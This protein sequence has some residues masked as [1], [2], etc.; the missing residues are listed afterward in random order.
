MAMGY[1]FNDRPYQ[2]YIK[3]QD[4]IILNN[5]ERK[6]LEHI[7]FDC[8]DKNYLV[9]ADKYATKQELDERINQNEKRK[10]KNK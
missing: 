2:Y 1:H 10:R 9:I 5:E 6:F 8:V 7:I 4:Y 3:N